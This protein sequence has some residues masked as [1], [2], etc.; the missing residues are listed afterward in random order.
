MSSLIYNALYVFFVVLE[1]ILFLYILTSWFPIGNR[2]KNMLIVLLD[3]IL[4][5]VRFLLKHSI[6]NTTAADLSPIIG[7]L[8][9]SFFQQFFYVLK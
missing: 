1:M 4:V 6:F 8:I 7:L 9:I 2:I 5:P 3:P